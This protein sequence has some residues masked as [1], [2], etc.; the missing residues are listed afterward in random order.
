MHWTEEAEAAVR[1]VPSFVRKKVPKRVVKEASEAQ[2]TQITIAE[3]KRTKACFLKKMSSEVKGYQL[4][5]CFGQ[6]GCPHR[7]M[8]SEH[9][10]KKLEQ[11]MS[12]ARLLNFL[13]K[14]S[15]GI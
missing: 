8:E 14:G 9:L 6:G 3:V 7:V 15:R 2:K 10:L 12:E 11:I 13:K 5:A 4:D 1:K